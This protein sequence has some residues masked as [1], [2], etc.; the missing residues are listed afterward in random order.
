MG[1]PTDPLRFD[2]ETILKEEAKGRSKFQMQYMLDNSLSD[3]ERY[4][5]KCSDLTVMDLDEDIAPEK[6]AHGSSSNLIMKD[7]PCYGIGGDK[8]YG[9]IPIEGIKW[10]PYNYKIMSIDPS[11]RG[12]DELA[13]T[14]TGVLNGQIFLLK[15]EGLQE[16]YCEDNLKYISVLAK[17]YRVNKIVIESNFGDGI[18][19]ALL[20]PVLNRI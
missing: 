5:L 16:G 6:A 18:F 11:G 4:P 1:T 2:E 9:N 14:I 13:L 19:N 12:K 8:F 10:L 3:L 7:L 15:N 20:S 17:K